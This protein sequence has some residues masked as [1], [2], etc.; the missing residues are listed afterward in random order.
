[1]PNAKSI[2]EKVALG[3]WEEALKGYKLLRKQKHPHLRDVIQEWENNV[4]FL[5]QILGRQSPEIYLMTVSQGF[6]NYHDFVN[7]M[8]NDGLRKLL[9][10]L[11]LFY[12][13]D[14]VIL[15][16]VNFISNFLIFGGK[17][18]LIVS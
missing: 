12:I 11:T 9:S 13:N 2:H 15:R 18:G 16:S 7:R 10:G 5:N 14:L 4:H 1:M 17:P 6:N 3:Q 8:G